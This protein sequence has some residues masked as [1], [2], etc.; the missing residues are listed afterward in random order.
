[1]RF[2][3]HAHNGPQSTHIRL[4]PYSPNQLQR[5]ELLGPLIWYLH[6]ADILSERIGQID[7]GFVSKEKLMCRN[8]VT[9]K[10][11]SMWVDLADEELRCL[12][13]GQHEDDYSLLHGLCV[14]VL[15]RWRPNGY[16]G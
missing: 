12:P 9:E 1:M 7:R 5:L 16:L 6:M 14:F 13:T 11:E 3:L 8:L 4:I 10:F 15:W 2:I